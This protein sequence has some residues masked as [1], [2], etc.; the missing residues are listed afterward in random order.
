MGL[1]YQQTQCLPF[2]SP[3]PSPLKGEG[4]ESANYFSAMGLPAP[5]TI[6]PQDLTIWPFTASGMGT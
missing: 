3:Q 2:P 6:C 5:S 4:V 1:A